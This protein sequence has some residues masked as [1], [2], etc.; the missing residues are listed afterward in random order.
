MVNGEEQM[1]AKLKDQPWRE[2]I[3]GHIN[4]YA[5]EANWA[6]VAMDPTHA[7]PGKELKKWNRW[8]ALD[9]DTN[10]VVVLDKVACA[11]GAEIEVRFHPS[12]EI[13]LS[14]DHVLLRAAAAPEAGGRGGRQGNA[15]AAAR[16]TPIPADG[17]HRYA[18]GEAPA[19]RP[20]RAEL[21]VVPIVNG[22]F[23]LVQGRQPDLP[24]MQEP[25]LSWA[26]YFSTI[27]KAPAEENVIATIFC[28]SDLRSGEGALTYKLDSTG[29]TP[30]LTYTVRG[31]TTKLSFT[32]DKITRSI[33]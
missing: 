28:P 9:K 11:I 14:K 12:V 20:R 25:Q 1:E 29:A 23:S 27:V 5:S 19:A 10:I 18:A 26:P 13:D 6:G 3:G 4:F 17:E 31:K 22:D 30:A 32:S 33:D 21:D 2:G 8:I 7:Y 24:V 16:P 15:A